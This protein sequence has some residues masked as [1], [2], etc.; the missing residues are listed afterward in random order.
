MKMKK[1]SLYISS[2]VLGAAAMQSC[3]DN[4]EQPPMS[5]PE[6]PEGTKATLTIKELK[7]KYWQDTDMYGAEVK[8]L[9]NGSDAVI[10]GNI[11]STTT[12]GNIYKALYLQDATGAI[13]L[14]ID[15][16]AVSVAYPQ[17]MKMAI[18]VTGLTI[19]RYNGMM[20][21]GQL[22][23]TSVN[24]IGM[25]ALRPHTMLAFR[26]K[27]EKI[28]TA[29]VT[30]AQLKEAAKTKEGMIEWQSRMVRLDGVKIKEAGEPFANGANTSRTIVDSEGNT[31]VLY[32]SSYATFANDAMP[33][34]TGSVVGIL[35]CYK[36]TWQLL[37]NDTDGLIAFDGEGAPDPREKTLLKEA[38]TADQ[39]AFTIET[40]VMGEGLSYVWKYDSN[41]KFMKAS[42]F[43]NSKSIAS[44][45]YLISPEVNLAGYSAPTLQFE[46]C[47]NKFTE[48]PASQVSVV[49]REVGTTTW[50]AVEIPVFSTNADWNFVASGALDL[51]A[52]A[53]KKIQFAFKY[54]STDASSGTWEVKNVTLKAIKE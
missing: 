30:I 9:D 15:T 19:G 2:L 26:T 53:G 48:N 20:Q 37:L 42:A 23:G 16:T 3:A 8:T 49:V 13:C 14:G 6:F 39:G 35:S 18:N 12:P 4:W 17:G 29:V 31:I 45:S 7:E 22:S 38:F 33:Y 24:R 41:Y 46:H 47:V 32:N 1:I 40:P 10:I 50:T 43:A 44:E 36:T 21:L 28:D 5:V 54:T 52:F 11:I 51:K 34:G 27:E 25:P